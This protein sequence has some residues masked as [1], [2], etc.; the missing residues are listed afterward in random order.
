MDRRLERFVDHRADGG[1]GRGQRNGD[2]QRR[3]ERRPRSARRHADDWRKDLYGE[4]GQPLMLMR[5]VLT[6]A[7]VVVTL[8]AW[9]R[10]AHAQQSLTGALSFL[11]TNRS[12]A[13]GDFGG[14]ERAA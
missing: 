7:L 10:P 12:I 6:V 11:L 1:D 14:D 2:V 3:Q 13:T 8:A 4:S 9:P 5:A